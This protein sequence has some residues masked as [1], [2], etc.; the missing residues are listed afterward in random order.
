MMFDC[1][2]CGDKFL[3]RPCRY[4][5]MGSVNLVPL[6]SMYTYCT[7][8]YYFTAVYFDTELLAS[9]PMLLPNIAGSGFT[10][11]C[12]MCMLGHIH[13]GC[14]C[15]I[16]V[17][18]QVSA[19]LFWFSRWLIGWSASCS[20]QL[21]SNRAWLTCFWSHDVMMWKGE[22]DDI[23]KKW[24]VLRNIYL[25]TSQNGMTDCK[26]VQLIQDESRSV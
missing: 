3:R 8:H 4:P 13:G 2:D 12:Q 10:Y 17:H 26:M 1:A 23:K 19:L 15:S 11:H 24:E 5:I 25:A 21:R 20:S 16:M 14:N 22:Q 9:G 18:L 7:L 6:L